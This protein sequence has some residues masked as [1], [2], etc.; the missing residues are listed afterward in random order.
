MI[1]KKILNIDN[2]DILILSSLGFYPLVPFSTLD[3][4]ISG[5]AV[6]KIR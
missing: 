2:V 4:K 1:I 5:F 6:G 3:T